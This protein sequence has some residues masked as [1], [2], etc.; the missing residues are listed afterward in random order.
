MFIKNDKYI[1]TI[2][3]WEVSQKQ[4]G[5]KNGEYSVEV[6]LSGQDYK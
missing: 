4:N 1:R 6:K 3:V 2:Y 5:L